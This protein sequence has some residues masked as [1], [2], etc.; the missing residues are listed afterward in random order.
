MALP[1]RISQITLNAT[2]W[3]T[4]DNNHFEAAWWQ[5][6]FLRYPRTSQHTLRHSLGKRGGRKVLLMYKA[7]PQLAPQ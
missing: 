7:N 3:F 5:Y 2:K 1:D 6:I 4:A